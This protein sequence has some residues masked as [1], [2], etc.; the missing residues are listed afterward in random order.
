MFKNSAKNKKLNSSILAIIILVLLLVCSFVLFFEINGY[1]TI[2]EE[3]F[4]F[5][6]YFANQRLDFNGK[7][8]FNSRDKILSLSGEGI[9]LLSSPVYYSNTDAMILP[10][11][12]EI[13]QPYKNSPMHNLGTFSK[14]YYRGNYLYANIENGIGRL[15]DCFLY[16]GNDLYVFIDDTTVIIGEDRY[17]LNPM[18]FIEVSRDTIEIYNKKTDFYTVLPNTTGAMAYTNEY[19]VDLVSDSVTY[20]STYYL[21]MKKPEALELYNF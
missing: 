6:Y 16:D 7:V 19:S 15:Y 12:M 3:K 14:I 21:L 18:S 9:T 2:Q 20:N 8:T 13:V 4:D 11:N 5:Y 1:R 17:E 10:S